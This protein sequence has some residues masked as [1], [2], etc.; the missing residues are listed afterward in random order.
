[1]KLKFAY[2]DV[3][4]FHFCNEKLLISSV[5]GLTIIDKDQMVLFVSER[6]VHSYIATD[7]L[8]F[9]QI[10]NGSDIYVQNNFGA[11]SILRGEYYLWKSIGINVNE[12][13]VRGKNEIGKKKVFICGY[14]EVRELGVDELPEIV[15]ESIGIFSKDALIARY[16]E[17]GQE[18]WRQ[19]LGFKR[20]IFG[21]VVRSD[22]RLI[23]PI[24]EN[25]NGVVLCIDINTGKVL[26]EKFAY[27]Y[28]IIEEGTNY[29]FTIQGYHDFTVLDSSNGSVVNKISNWSSNRL[30]PNLSG[31][32]G[33]AASVY[34]DFIVI[35]NNET[36]EVFFLNKETAAVVDY[37]KLDVPKR[38]SRQEVRIAQEPIYHQGKLFVLDSEN[39]LHIY[40]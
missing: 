25:D 16:F 33:G 15:Y 22:G 28:P 40:E 24:L 29:I 12:I 23:V 6:S 21:N 7:S 3:N 4:N 14:N 2:R 31:T 11:K 39:T 32:F 5:N 37:V 38:A 17:S 19:V 26:W 18:L 27:P 30:Y 35:P 8:I 1:M 9:Y 20:K 34:K 13:L 36:C 10:E